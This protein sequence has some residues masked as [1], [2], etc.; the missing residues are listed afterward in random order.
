MVKILDES[1]IHLQKLEEEIL[2]VIMG[3]SER[4]RETER[5]R[6]GQAGSPLAL[7]GTDREREREK[8]RELAAHSADIRRLE[9]ANQLLSVDR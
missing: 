3:E 2:D 7:M 5:E 4:V 8:E 1:K 9:E 6:E